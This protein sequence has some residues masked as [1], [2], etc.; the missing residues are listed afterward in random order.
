M[1]LKYG[2]RRAENGGYER[3]YLSHLHAVLVNSGFRGKFSGTESVED[4]FELLH[5]TSLGRRAARMFLLKHDE[6]EFGPEPNRTRL[7][8]V[9]IAP[10]VAYEDS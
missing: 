1:A 4:L 10:R 8:T 2:D 5:T 6:G 9:R 7:K 3:A